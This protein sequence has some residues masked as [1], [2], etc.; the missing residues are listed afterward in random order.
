[1]A[2]PVYQPW[3]DQAAADGRIQAVEFSALGY[4]DCEARYLLDGEP[5][6]GYCAQRYPDGTLQ[7][8]Y[9]LTDGIEHG[10]TVS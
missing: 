1:M 9:L 6:T 3:L 8:V 10:H 5:F 2:E 4:D 7:C